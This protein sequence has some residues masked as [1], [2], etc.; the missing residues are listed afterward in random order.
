MSTKWN[1]DLEHNQFPFLRGGEG[2]W[3]GGGG[4]EGRGGRWGSGMAFGFLS[5]SLVNADALFKTNKRIQVSAD[6]IWMK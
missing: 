5:N 4:L 3:L 2:G 6:D 1:F